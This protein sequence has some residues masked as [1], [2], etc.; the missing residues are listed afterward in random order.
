MLNQLRNLHGPVWVGAVAS[1]AM[2]AI[3]AAVLLGVLA[4]NLLDAGGQAEP[5]DPYDVPQAVSAADGGVVIGVSG[6]TFSGTETRVTLTV[7]L[8]PGGTIS[9]D[10]VALVRTKASDFAAGTLRPLE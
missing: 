5:L 8:L 1:V 10:D 4:A 7:T 6:A 9:A 3:V 2:A